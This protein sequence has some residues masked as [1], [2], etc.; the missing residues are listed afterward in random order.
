MR[1]VDTNVLIR[2]LTQDDPEQFAVAK[3]FVAENEVFIPV[4]V[5]LE[6]EWVLRRSYGFDQRR[7]AAELRRLSAV[8]SISVD[9]LEQVRQALDLVDDGLDFADALH[10]ARSAGCNDFVTFDAAMVRG[11]ASTLPPVT[12]LGPDNDRRET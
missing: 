3:A 1:A 2:L 9:D 5:L 11:A 12:L 7:I 4:T 6:A 10:L 8:P